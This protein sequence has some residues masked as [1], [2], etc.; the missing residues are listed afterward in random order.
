MRNL[1]PLGSPEDRALTTYNQLQRAAGSAS[2]RL[3]RRVMA[4]EHLTESQIGV[5][6]ALFRHGPLCHRVLAERLAKTSGNVTLVVDNLEK[7]SLVRRE[8][9]PEDRRLVSVVLTPGGRRLAEEVLPR[10]VAGIVEEMSP[11]TAAEQEELGR[12]CGKLGRRGA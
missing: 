1:E 6:E 9:N 10:I 4:R 2:A 3:Q 11:L 8:R 12:L 7:R 5:L